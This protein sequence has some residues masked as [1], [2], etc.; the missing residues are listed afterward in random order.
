MMTRDFKNIVMTRDWTEIFKALRE[1]SIKHDISFTNLDF[2][3]FWDGGC[4]TMQ[5]YGN[6]KLE[7]EE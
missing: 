2:L 7:S 6:I 1:F 4:Y 3:S 5:Q